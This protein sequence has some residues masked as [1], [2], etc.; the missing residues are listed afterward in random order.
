MKTKYI[1]NSFFS[2][3]FLILKRWCIVNYVTE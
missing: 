2:Y 1:T 3:V